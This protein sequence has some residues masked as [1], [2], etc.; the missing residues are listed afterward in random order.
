MAMDPTKHNCYEKLMA[1]REQGLIPPG[2]ISEVDICHNDW[3]EIYEG[4]YCN[5]D[6]DIKL[7]EAFGQYSK[8]FDR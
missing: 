1:L 5:C 6:P 3:C 4:G 8:G 7:H 2:S